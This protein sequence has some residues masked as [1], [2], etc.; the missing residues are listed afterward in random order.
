MYYYYT[1]IYCIP[2]GECLQLPVECKQYLNNWMS[3]L[4]S[5]AST[6]MFRSLVAGNKQPRLVVRLAAPTKEQKDLLE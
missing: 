6:S 5:V 2:T 1:I 3:L 4:F